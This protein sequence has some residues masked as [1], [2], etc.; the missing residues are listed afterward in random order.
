MGTLDIG[1]LRHAA[2]E[3]AAVA[4]HPRI[5][6]RTASVLSQ[7]AAHLVELAEILDLESP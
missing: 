3:V 4:S 1:L 2:D 7:I 6:P 5:E